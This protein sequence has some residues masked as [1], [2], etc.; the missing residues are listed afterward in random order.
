MDV[1]RV[2]EFAS[3]AGVL[4]LQSGGETY[5]VEETVTT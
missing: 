1:N 5:R 3:D 2:L 4:L